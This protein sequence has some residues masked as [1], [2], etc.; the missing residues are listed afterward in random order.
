[1][2]NYNKHDNLYSTYDIPPVAKT[3]SSFTAIELIIV[4]CCDLNIMKI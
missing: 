3:P 2:F 1:M 4:F